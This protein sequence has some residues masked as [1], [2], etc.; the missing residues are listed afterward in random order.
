ML[1]Y[2]I[3]SEQKIC[4][5]ASLFVYLIVFLPRVFPNKLFI[6]ISFKSLHQ[7]VLE[8]F[9]PSSR[10]ILYN[11]IKKLSR[12]KWMKIK[13]PSERK[14]QIYVPRGPKNLVDEERKVT[15]KYN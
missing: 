9:F 10:H 5:V 6:I 11:L 3:Q 14:V 12:R 15:L 1:D 7:T 4:Y 2:E 8:S 13:K